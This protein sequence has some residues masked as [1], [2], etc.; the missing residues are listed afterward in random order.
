MSSITTQF[1]AH[2]LQELIR[3]VLR[4]ALGVAH[5]K[6]GWK[7]HCSRAQ[8]DAFESD[9]TMA[10]PLITRGALRLDDRGERLA[11]LKASPWNCTVISLLSEKVH[12]DAQSHV[13][14]TQ[15]SNFDGIDWGEEVRRRIYPILS[16]MY[17][18]RR[19]KEASQDVGL[20]MVARYS[21]RLDRNFQRRIRQWKFD[22][23][24]AIAHNM[25]SAIG[26]LAKSGRTDSNNVAQDQLPFW[27]DAYVAV[28][29]LGVDGMSDEEDGYDGDEEIRLVHDITFRHPRLRRFLTTVDG[30]RLLETVV[31]PTNGRRR[32]RR[33]Y[34]GD[35]RDR[36]PPAGLP[37]VFY[38]DGYL[39][40]KTPSEVHRLQVNGEQYSWNIFDV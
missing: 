21:K 3:A 33:V 16:D 28:Q 15:T 1:N 10:M 40:R 18:A 11:D 29:L 26:V 5:L 20:Q 17:A 31:T 2:H 25:L 39:A 7:Q 13:M 4:D 34:I 6:D 9:P 8:L 37:S 22:N 32:R 24:L 19:S 35:L 36:D 30:A 27:R 14:T 38:R 12:A 23:R